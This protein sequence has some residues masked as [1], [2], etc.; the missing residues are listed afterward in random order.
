MPSRMKNQRG[1]NIINI[2][3][4]I[5]L[6]ANPEPDSI[7]NG[8]GLR[9][10]IWTKGCRHCCPGCHNTPE[11]RS[12][13]QGLLKSPEDLYREISGFELQS[14]VT[15]SGGD[16]M[17]QATACSALARMLKNE[18]INLWCY[19]GYLFEELQE[20]EDC[21]GFLKYIDVLVDGKFKIELKSYDLL[22]KGS[23]NQRLIDVQKSLSTGK[24]ELLSLTS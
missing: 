17:E 22:F 4:M 1:S 6:A 7:V 18:G 12:F 11:S 8:P 19:S 13:N 10:V 3:D 15:F 16:P 23:S 24:A 21:M 9:T 20:K 2:S 5:N 14:G